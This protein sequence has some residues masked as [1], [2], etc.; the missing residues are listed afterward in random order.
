[1]Y[2]QTGRFCNPPSPVFLG[3]GCFQDL[4]KMR[5]EKRRIFPNFCRSVTKPYASYIVGSTH[6][7]LN[8]N[9]L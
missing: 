2:F 7:S 3:V 9:V 8:F 4:A 5:S 1:M 6:L